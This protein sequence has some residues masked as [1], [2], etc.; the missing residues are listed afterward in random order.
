MLQSLTN[1]P[2]V[3]TVENT[4]GMIPSVKFSREFFLARFAVYNTVG[5][6]F[7][8]ISNRMSDGLKNYRRSIF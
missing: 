1:F 7:F 6:L 2:S 5:V 4:D 8:L 3:I